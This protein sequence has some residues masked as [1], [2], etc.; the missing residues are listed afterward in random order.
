MSASRLRLNPSKTNVLWL[1]SRQQLQKIQVRTI[2]VLSVTIPVTE[3]A[4][5]LGVVVDSQLTL[6]GHVAALCRS[7]YF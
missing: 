4:Y 3:S 7:T 2:S 5:D 1:E 6:S